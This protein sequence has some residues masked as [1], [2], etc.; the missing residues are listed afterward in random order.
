MGKA[1]M[2]FVNLKQVGMPPLRAAAYLAAGH[3]AK[4]GRVLILAA[5]QEEA[6]ALDRELWIYDPGSFL[7]HALAG[8]SDQGLEPVL[9]STSPENLNQAQVLISTRSLPPDTPLEQYAHLVVLVPA[10]EGPELEACRRCYKEMRERPVEL[11]HTTELARP[12]RQ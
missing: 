9:I 6:Q 1:L 5:D 7:P 2:E 11:R 12:E 4:G 10:Q 3:Y 8:E